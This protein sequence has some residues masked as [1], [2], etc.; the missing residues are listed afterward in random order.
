LASID[1]TAYP[2]FKRAVS[3]REMAEVFT[4]NSR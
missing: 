3:V 4:P 1:P 2:R